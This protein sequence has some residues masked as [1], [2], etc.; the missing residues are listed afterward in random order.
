MWGVEVYLHSFV[1][2]DLDGGEYFHAPTA[3]VAEKSAG[4]PIAGGWEGFRDDLD[5]SETKIFCPCW[6]S[7][8]V[9]CSH[10]AVTKRVYRLR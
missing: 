1:I 10:S 5:V 8:F 6:G 7:N 2:S 4:N 3:F 9:S